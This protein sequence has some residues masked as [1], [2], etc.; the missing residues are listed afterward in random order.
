LLS[1]EQC[2]EKSKKQKHMDNQQI[3]QNILGE[4]EL[5]ISKASFTTWFTNTSLVSCE[6]REAIISVPNLFTQEWLENKYQKLILH[7]LTN[8]TGERPEKIKYEVCS[9][10]NQN[11]TLPLSRKIAKTKTKEAR[12]QA[13]EE[14][15]NPLNRINHETNLN[16]RY[17]F[18]N[19]VVGANNELAR[20]ACHAVACNPGL[21]Y[22]PL[23]IYGGVGLGKTHL[24]Q[25][26]GNEITK[27]FQTKKVKY[28]ASERFTDELVRAI[29]KHDVNFFKERYRNI[30]VMIVDDVQFIA[31][32][33]KTQEEFFNIFNVLYGENKQIVISSDRPP[34]AIP[35]LEER[36]SSRFEGGMVA[37]I[38]LPDL[39]TRIA[40]LKN[41]AEKVGLNFN[42]DIL[43]YIA[44]NIQRNI[45]ELEGALNRVIAN[46]QLA[47]FPLTLLNVQKVLKNV[48]NAPRPHLASAK[49][50]IGSVV[51]F[52]NLDMKDLVS[53]SRKKE[54]SYPRQ[55]LMY[56]LRVEAKISY[57]SIGQELGGRD[58]TTVIHAYK[59]ISGEINENEEVRREIELIK[60]RI[61]A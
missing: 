50:I 31:G 52:Y 45:R 51:Q 11:Q 54:I 55:I 8:A 14:N 9:L 13:I 25:A 24:L 47:P 30:D 3:W 17:T 53:D 44:I 20:A 33:E 23:F 19:F 4:L 42:N 41:K 28:V 59:K 10:K 40:I 56:L 58:H 49:E 60:Q 34:K 46:Y 35:A 43:S 38:I 37:D 21:T 12:V 57:P 29:Q 39:E 1:T 15:S 2:P 22:N 32:K 7:A 6:N 16:P 18:D 5:S 48:I 27:K 61:Y 26:V 36:L